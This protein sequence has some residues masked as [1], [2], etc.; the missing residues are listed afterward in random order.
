M[1]KTKGWRRLELVTPLL[2]IFTTKSESNVT[3]TLLK[4]NWRANE[5]SHL[6]Y[7]NLAQKTLQVPMLT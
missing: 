1:S 5:I 3:I 6:K 4:P 7:H 2:I